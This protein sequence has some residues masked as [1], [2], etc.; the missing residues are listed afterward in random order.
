MGLEAAFL[1]FGALGFLVGTLV[2]FFAL[3]AAEAFFALGAAALG[4]F[5]FFGEDLFLGA[6]FLAGVPAEAAAP[7]VAFLAAGF[8]LVAF[9]TPDLRRALGADAL[10][11]SGLAE[12]DSLNDPEAPLPLVWTSSPD[13]Q[14]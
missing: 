3:G 5:A 9:F 8:A 11:P 1:G 7:E 12:P 4:D 14:A 13:E 10:P 2:T 6:F